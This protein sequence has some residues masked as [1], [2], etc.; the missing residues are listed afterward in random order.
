MSARLKSIIQLLEFVASIK[1]SQLREQ[2]LKKMSKRPEVY[3]ALCEIAYSTVSKNISLDAA[4][5]KK[6]KT[7]KST[8]VELSCKHES[9]RKKQK[10]VVQSGGFLPILIP[11]AL[12]LL[13]GIQS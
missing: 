7:Y 2:L 10:L 11:L 6:L 4:H 13:N 1:S 3:K 12:A 5:K 8:I 9:R